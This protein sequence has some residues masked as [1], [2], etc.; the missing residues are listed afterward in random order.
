[1]YLFLFSHLLYLDKKGSLCGRWCVSAFFSL[2]NKQLGHHPLMLSRDCIRSQQV[3]FIIMWLLMD[4][5]DRLQRLTY[6]VTI[7]HILGWFG[8]WI[9]N[10]KGQTEFWTDFFWDGISKI[11]IE[12]KILVFLNIEILF[13]YSSGFV[14]SCVLNLWSRRRSRWRSHSVCLWLCFDP[15]RTVEGKRWN[16]N[17]LRLCIYTNQPKNTLEIQIQKSKSMHIMT[18]ELTLHMHIESFF[19]PNSEIQIQIQKQSKKPQ[20]WQTLEINH[21]NMQKQNPRFWIPI[22][23][24]K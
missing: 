19:F 14:S 20:F 12:L 6:K 5:V 24:R 9:P 18:V 4:Q 7:D 8:F 11:E 22:L 10:R 17:G 13:R 1:M 2:K 15:C 21:K 23:F 3:R 16:H